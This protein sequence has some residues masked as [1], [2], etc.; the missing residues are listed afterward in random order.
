MIR[1]TYMCYSERDRGRTD[2][3]HRINETVLSWRKH[4][5]SGSICR[6]SNNND[7][8]NLFIVINRWF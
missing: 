7:K 4:T 5:G 1:K 8:G 6:V 3:I 2:E